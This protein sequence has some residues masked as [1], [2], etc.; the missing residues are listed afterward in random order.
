MTPTLEALEGSLQVPHK[1]CKK[2]FS[3]ETGGKGI[4][5]SRAGAVNVLSTAI[6]SLRARKTVVLHI[7]HR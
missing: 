2:A 6:V 3:R 7:L 5:V 4:V 1:T